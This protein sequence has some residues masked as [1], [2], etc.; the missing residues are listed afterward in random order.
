MIGRRLLQKCVLRIRIRLQPR[1]GGG[2]LTHVCAS[3]HSM[4]G[5]ISSSWEITKTEI[6]LKVEIPLNTTAI[7]RNINN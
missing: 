3:H 7:D 4:Y 2:E 5:R 1:I 6:S